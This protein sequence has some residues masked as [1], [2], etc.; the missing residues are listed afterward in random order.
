MRNILLRDL[1]GHYIKR[2]IMST[3]ISGNIKFS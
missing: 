2:P 3:E 1:K